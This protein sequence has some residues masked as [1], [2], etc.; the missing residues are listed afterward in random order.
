MSEFEG[1]PCHRI[2][3]IDDNVAI[4]DDFRKVLMK[5]EPADN[6][7]EQM[8][9]ALFGSED[10]GRPAVVF[11]IDCASQGREGLE[12]VKQAQTE[13]RPYSLVFVDGRMPPGWDGIET[14]R[15]L[16][17]ESPELQV[18]L[19]TAYADYS[20]QEI[21]SVLGQSDSLLILKKPFDNAEI[22]QMAHALTRKWELNREILGRLNKLAFFDQ[23]TGLPNRSLFMDRLRQ[24]VDKARCYKH[25]GALFFIDLDNFKRINDT[26]GHNVGDELLKAVGARL[27]QCLR[28][29]DT[30]ARPM[31]K[32][33]M[34]AR[35][36]GDE[37]TVLLPE[38]GKPEFAAVVAQRITEQLSKP[39]ELGGHQVIVTPSIGIAIFPQD[40]EDVDSLLKNADMA[41]YYAK[42]IGPS[43]FKYYQESMN[44]VALKRLKIENHL[45]KALDRREFSLRFQPQVDL[46]SGQIRGMEALL[47]WHNEELGEVPPAEFIPIAEES[48]LIL[49]IGE[50]VL[51]TACIQAAAWLKQGLDLPRI[52]VNVSI[53]QFSQK[54]FVETVGTILAEAGLEAQQ[55]EMEITESLLAQDLP[56]VLTI[57]H[58]LREM[59]VRIAVDDFGNGYSSLYRLREMPIDCLKI[60]RS[61]VGGIEG[62]AKD[63]SII[64]AI[65]TMADGLDLIVIAEGVETDD[66]ADFLR[67]KECSQAQGF[68]FGRPLTTSQAETLLREHRN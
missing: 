39:L 9:S 14:I 33:P 36:G 24:T 52:A 66:Q 35:L 12:M 49:A 19:C 4:N 34:A 18:V 15:H 13:N 20:W 54:N 50:W 60:D 41:M 10:E 62:G 68:L 43:A 57:L 67:S 56:E 28:A 23:L 63:R 53:K 61:F 31:E 32:F 64:N 47:R 51:R 6:V 25:T 38:M 16:W 59:G 3:V 44:A 58:A 48:G 27:S 5:P 29:S 55:L 7:L 17:Q 40:G 26:L 21:Q 37:F 2:L 45:R 22:L 11:E 8:E 46:R 1:T 65:I 30:I 42:S